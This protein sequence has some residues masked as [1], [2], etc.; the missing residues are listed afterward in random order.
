M[1]SLQDEKNTYATWGWSWTASQDPTAVTE[2]ADLP[3]VITNVD[4]HGDTEGDD[5]WTYLMMYRRTGN[6]VYLNRAQAWLS[7]FKNVYR[8]SQAFADDGGFLH[9][10][11][12]GWGL[13]TWYEHTCEQGACDTAAL[14]EA[15]NLAAVSETYWNGLDSDGNPRFVAGQYRMATYGIR[16][17]ARHLLLATRVAEVTGSPRW[18]ALRDKLINL[19]MQSPDWDSRG[20]Y[21]MTGD[22]YF[23][24]RGIS[25]THTYHQAILTEA[26]AHVVR[27]TGRTDVRDRIV[28]MA[29]FDAQ[30]GLDP[31]YQYSG[32]E[33]GFAPDGSLFHTYSDG[34]GTTCTFWDSVYTTSLVNTLVRGYKYTGD[35]TLYQRAKYF[36]NR[37]TKAVY[38]E[39][40][41]R[42]AADNQVGHFIDTQ[43]ASSTNFVYL[44]NNKGELQYT[45]LMFEPAPSCN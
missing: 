10:H 13:V 30:Y 4:V 24:Q 5:L 37:G 14:D 2:R 6:P 8:T 32:K 12:Y 17:G 35:C 27:T 7:Y 34:C 16:A 19:W 25:V 33:F 26:F 15:Q 20:M 44:D 38:G 18:I 29:R 28:A 1:S 21:V 23:T 3:Y 22:D 45:Y 43:F 31:Y 9:D 39:P 42:A 40:L 36:F 41:Q 11:F